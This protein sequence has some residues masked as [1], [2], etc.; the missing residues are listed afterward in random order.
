MSDIVWAVRSLT[1]PTLN[2]AL[3]R[4]WMENLNAL[5]REPR[6]VVTL[7]VQGRAEYRQ[8]VCVNWT[9]H[10]FQYAL[11]TGWWL[12]P[13]L[14]SYKSYQLMPSCFHGLSCGFTLRA[15]KPR[16]PSFNSIDIVL[17]SVCRLSAVS[18]Y[19]LVG[20]SRWAAVVK[21]A[22]SYVFLPSLMYRIKNTCFVVSWFRLMSFYPSIRPFIHSFRR[23]VFYWTQQPASC[24][25]WQ[26]ALYNSLRSEAC[27]LW[28]DGCC[29]IHCYVCGW[30]YDRW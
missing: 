4:W 2:F 1:I 6:I 3:R 15:E 9:S 8:V 5:Y 27:A 22:P 14:D 26:C 25:C 20:L 10:E 29:S 7:H 24:V 11:L 12:A 19:S 17:C 23:S 28:T 18:T 30:C 21:V 16:R 13:F